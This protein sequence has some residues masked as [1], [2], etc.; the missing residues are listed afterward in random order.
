MA[1]LQHC[2]LCMAVIPAGDNVG[3]VVIKRNQKSNAGDAEVET[4]DDCTS[5]LLGE[6]A[7]KEADESPPQMP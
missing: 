2:D 5:R 4:C 1:L 6:I 7:T 3:L